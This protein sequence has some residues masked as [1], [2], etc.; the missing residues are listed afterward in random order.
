MAVDATRIS[1]RLRALFPKA[2]LSTQRLNEISV[3]L[4][5]MPADDADDDT[6]DAVINQA[7]E[8]T[9]FS[10]IA[11][12]DDKIRDLESKIKK[13]NP[14]EPNRNPEQ[15]IDET[16]G[17]TPFE[18]MMLQKF[19]ALETKISGFETQQSQK[20]LSERFKSSPELK[21]VPEFMFKGRIP[22]TEEDFENAVSELKTDYT[23]FA[24]E[25]KL[26]I[27]GSDVPNTGANFKPNEKSE[28]SPAIKAFAESQK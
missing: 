26:S 3:R 23:S 12:S 4:S 16:E 9:P 25:N 14:N 18:K 17:M 13:P 5:K 11:K 21:G 28:V 15:V 24:T 1:G 19:G 2:N 8:F 10:E 22:T 20:T 6:V 7:N 27:L